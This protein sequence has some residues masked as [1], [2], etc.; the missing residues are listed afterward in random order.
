MDKQMQRGVHKV[1]YFFV[2][3]AYIDMPRRRCAI[4]LIF[5]NNEQ[6]NKLYTH[7]RERYCQTTYLFFHQSVQGREAEIS[8]DRVVGASNFYNNEEV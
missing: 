7:S 4:I 5:V 6:G 1:G 3:P 2:N 8:W